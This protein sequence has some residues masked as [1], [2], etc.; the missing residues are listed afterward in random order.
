MILFRLVLGLMFVLSSWSK[1]RYPRIF[2]ESLLA[3]AVLPESLVTLTALV[4]PWLELLAGLSVLAGYRYRGSSIVLG[5]LSL[6]FM[7][8]ASSAVWKGLDISCGCFVGVD[9]LT[10]DWKH[11]L[12][13]AALAAF[14]GL[15]FWKGPGALSVERSAVK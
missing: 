8:V 4:L 9:W 10:V 2:A 14:A 12:V 13:N 3:Y 15:V 7:V 1:L 6:L 11:I 5:S